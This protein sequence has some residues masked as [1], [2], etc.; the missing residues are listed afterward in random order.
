MR[1]QMCRIDHQLVGLARLEYLV[2]HGH[3]APADKPIVDRLGWPILCWSVAPAQ[4]VATYKNEAADYPTVV[5]TRN[6]VRQRKIRLN[7]AHSRLGQPNQ[8]T[9]GDASFVSPLE[10]KA[11]RAQ[12]ASHHLIKHFNRS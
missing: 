2:E 4:P 3:L 6:D 7:L 8:I 1:L 11:C 5:K 9:H 10:P 12:S